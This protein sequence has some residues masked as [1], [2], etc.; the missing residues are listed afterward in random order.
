MREAEKDGEPVTREEAREMAEMEVK[1]R[2]IKR[3]EREAPPKAEKDKRRRTVKTSP[4]KIELFNSILT[5]LDRCDGVL[6]ENIEV[7]KE[8]KL[9]SVRIGDKKFKIDIIQN[10]K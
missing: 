3:Y 8:N 7:L 2:G 1:A 4:E 6:H 5:N 9:I 10:K